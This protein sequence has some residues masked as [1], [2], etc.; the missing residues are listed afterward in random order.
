MTTYNRWIGK[1]A[2]ATAAV[3][4]L[5]PLLLG[6][7][8]G[9]TEATLRALAKDPATL[10]VTLITPWGTQKLYRS[11]NTTG[12]ATCD[13]SRLTIA[14]PAPPMPAAPRPVPPTP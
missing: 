11:G 12:G 9:I 4:A 3:V 6:G 5:A 7:C 1:R 2:K 10:C 8:V 14:N 13:D